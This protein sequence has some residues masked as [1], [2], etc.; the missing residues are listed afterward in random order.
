MSPLFQA[1]YPEWRVRMGELLELAEGFC[2]EV[3]DLVLDSA[4]EGQ[5][6]QT[7]GDV[8]GR[9]SSED[10]EVGIDGLCEALFQS[11]VERYPE[12]N[13]RI[14]SEH[15]PD[16][17]GSEDPD[18]LC[19]L[20]PFDGSDQYRKGIRE[21]WFSVFSFVK[22]DGTSLA[23]ACV[24]IL[25]GQLY[26]TDGKREITRVSLRSEQ[27]V[28]VS[29]RKEV[30]LSSE[31]V[32]A[33]YKGKWRYFDPWVLNLNRLFSQEELAGV[34]HTG[35]GGAYV[36]AFLAAGVFSA[37]I[38]FGEPT[39]E[40]TP[41]AAFVQAAGLQLF[42]VVD[43]ELKSFHPILGPQDAE[44]LDEGGRVE[45]FIAV[46]TKGLAEHIVQAHTA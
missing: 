3:I 14:I 29:P 41:G 1:D 40:I 43:G 38:M 7:T 18:I 8:P 2:R 10:V 37:Y 21:A 16:G 39:D 31:S 20:D 12:L 45:F 36:Y 9:E 19:Y 15:R 35:N 30:T 33:A 25:A 46:P 22:P 32:V 23:G 4:D 44:L 28:N 26:L 34:T 17:Y 13:I 6:R 11:W 24:D 27:R 5:G 42:A